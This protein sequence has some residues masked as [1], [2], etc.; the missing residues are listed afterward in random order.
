MALTYTIVMPTRTG[1]ER[2]HEYVSSEPLRPGEV[3]VIGERHWL[4]DRIDPAGDDGNG[5]AYAASARYRFRLRYPD[6]HEELGAFRRFRPGGPGL[7][8]A[9]TILEDGQPTSWSV[10]EQRTVQDENGQPYLDLLAERDYGEADGELPDH[11]LE[12]ALATE[13]WSLS[14]TAT[15]TLSRAAESGLSVELVALEPGEVPDWDEA[16]RYI[17]TLVIEEIGDD[18]L[19]LCHADRVPHEEALAIV[20]ERLGTDLER[21]RADVEGDHD[22][23]EE[24]DFRGGRI[25]ASVGGFDDESDPDSGHGWMCRLVDSGAL[26]AAGLRRVRK[27][28]LV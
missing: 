9:F 7:G 3:I 20:Q 27:T 17:V 13:D 2:T 25:F 18:L 23:I 22:E 28:E 8:H 24:W 15:A 16:A 10:V 26:A 1:G 12:H 5:R 6:G 11:E 19:Q 21:V 4:V 14:E